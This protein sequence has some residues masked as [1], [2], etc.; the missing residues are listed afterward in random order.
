VTLFERHWRA[1]LVGF[2]AAALGGLAALGLDDSD[3]TILAGAALA[4]IGGIYLGFAIADG[5]TSAIVIQAASVLAFVIVAYIGIEEGSKAVIGA[6]WIAHGFW[7]AL[8]HEHH[9]PTEV[10]TW[11]P[12]FCATAD[13]VVGIPLIAGLT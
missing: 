9:G 12:P 3:S 11:Y 7:D 10:K 13:L 1:I 8:H 4:A 2:V 5:R 6:G